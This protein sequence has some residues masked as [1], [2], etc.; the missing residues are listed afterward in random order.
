MIPIYLIIAFFLILTIVYP[1]VIIIA[2]GV[3]WYD[4][5]RLAFKKKD[6]KDYM[7]TIERID[8]RTDRFKEIFFNVAVFVILFAVAPFGVLYYFF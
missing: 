7:D 8:Q 5:K 4:K 3:G 2:S 1:L 6:S